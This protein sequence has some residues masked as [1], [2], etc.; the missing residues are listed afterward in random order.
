M[1][2]GLLTQRRMGF[3]V[4]KWHDQGLAAE[5]NRR[6]HP[7]RSDESRSPLARPDASRRDPPSDGHEA[8][9]ACPSQGISRV[10]ISQILH[11]R[12]PIT[13]EMA[14]R[15]GQVTGTAPDYWLRLQREFD[16]FQANRRLR[17]VLDKLPVFQ[18]AEDGERAHDVGACSPPGAGDVAFLIKAGKSE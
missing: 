16:L 9:G 3:T 1:C 15:L 4:T 13:T 5:W 10:R 17:P 14:L 7:D 8:G 18:M 2:N 11:G 12:A 6:R